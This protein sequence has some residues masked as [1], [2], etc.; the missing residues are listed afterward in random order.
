MNQTFLVLTTCLVLVTISMGCT[1]K[2]EYEPQNIFLG[3]S[4]TAA[5][6]ENLMI[7]LTDAHRFINQSR[8]YAI[9]RIFDSEG[10]QMYGR[11][12]TKNET[13]TYDRYN[14]TLVSVS[15]SMNGCYA[16]LEIRGENQYV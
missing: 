1:E 10:L 5:I 3:V 13:V 6:D 7:E 8:S 11:R 4:E 12:I 9:I 15:T 14:I 2:Q 16:E